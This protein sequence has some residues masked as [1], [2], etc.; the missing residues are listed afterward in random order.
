MK[1]GLYICGIISILGFIIVGDKI[2]KE[3]INYNSNEENSRKKT[4]LD[5]TSISVK[6]IDSTEQIA[7]SEGE[8]MNQWNNN[9]IP[10]IDVDSAEQIAKGESDMVIEATDAININIQDITNEQLTFY[11]ENTSKERMALEELFIMEFVN[12][13]WAEIERKSNIVY[14]L[15][16]TVI[17]ADGIVQ[18][19]F[20][21]KSLYGELDEGSYICVLVVNGFEYQYD[22]KID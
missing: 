19:D 13:E 21:Y 10:T 2:N 22:F 7:I 18:I 15:P 3:I 4:N 12:G 16:A 14:E 1:K 20:D 5:N 9:D 17:P 6:D 11:C 8:K